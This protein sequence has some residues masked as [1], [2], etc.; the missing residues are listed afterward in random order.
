MTK[1]IT[2]QVDKLLCH[3]LGMF[4]KKLAIALNIRTIADRAIAMTATIA[5]PR[6]QIFWGHMV[7]VPTV[8]LFTHNTGPYL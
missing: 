5:P 2:M 8:C 3:Q 7:L 1:L 4:W 6:K